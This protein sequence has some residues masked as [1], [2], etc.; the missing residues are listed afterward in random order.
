MHSKLINHQFQMAHTALRRL[1]EKSKEISKPLTDPLKISL[2]LEIN[3]E[4]IS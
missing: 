4:I 3:Q 2:G 1:R